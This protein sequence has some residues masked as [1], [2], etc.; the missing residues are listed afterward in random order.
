[1]NRANLSGNGRPE[2]VR[3]CCDASTNDAPEKVQEEAKTGPGKLAAMKAM[4]RAPFPNYAEI[5]RKLEVSVG[6]V[7][8]RARRLGLPTRSERALKH[9]EEIE[10]LVSDV[11]QAGAARKLGV[12]RQCVHG[13]LGKLARMRGAI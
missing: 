1:M 11:G 6:S 12:T 8:Q 7:S 9:Y 5:A 10:K 3:Q 4:L 13:C 2:Y